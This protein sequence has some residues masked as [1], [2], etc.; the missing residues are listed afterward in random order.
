MD[1][2]IY[3]ISATKCLGYRSVGTYLV[4]Q[5]LRH[6]MKLLYRNLSS[7]TPALI[8]A[9]LKLLTQMALHGSSLANELQSTF[10]FGL[11]VRVTILVQQIWCTIIMGAKLRI[12]PTYRLL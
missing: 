7:G 12:L 10:N 3:T 1:A 2:F 5:I 9:T 4:R 8:Q 11:N 6:H